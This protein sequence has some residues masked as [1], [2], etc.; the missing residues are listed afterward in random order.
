MERIWK[1]ATTS[2][3]DDEER[4][5]NPG[6]LA[7]GGAATALVRIHINNYT[8]REGTRAVTAGRTRASAARNALVHLTAV[9]ALVPSRRVQLYIVIVRP[10]RAPM[11]TFFGSLS[12]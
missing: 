7:C 2:E 5:N 9:T 6:I 11:L 3:N 4:H 12:E 10:T 1:D 8:L